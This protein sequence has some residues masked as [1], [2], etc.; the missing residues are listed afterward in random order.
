[1]SDGKEVRTDLT[2]SEFPAGKLD[3]GEAETRVSSELEEALKK[4][5]PEEVERRR[6]RLSSS[7]YRYTSI[8]H[9]FSL[10]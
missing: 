7:I 10:T 1:M 4:L 5:N 9:I 8:C 2:G 6:K 3:E